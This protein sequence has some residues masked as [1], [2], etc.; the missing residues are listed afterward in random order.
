M[1]EYQTIHFRIAYA[2]PNESQSTALPCCSRRLR[3]TWIAT[4]VIAFV[5]GVCL[6]DVIEFGVQSSFYSWR[7]SNWAWHLGLRLPV[8]ALIQLALIEWLFHLSRT[9]CERSPSSFIVPLTAGFVN[10]QLY[11]WIR[12]LPEQ[13]AGL[14]VNWPLHRGIELCAFMGTAFIVVGVS[15]LISSCWPA[16]SRRTT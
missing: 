13:I 4:F 16:G 2:S 8:Y 5:S 7:T 6:F 3:P 10:F 14:T 9:G 1:T 11:D 15:R 12:I